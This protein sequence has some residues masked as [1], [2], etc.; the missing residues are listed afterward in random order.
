MSEYA[1]AGVDYRKIEPFKDAMVEV[2]KKTKNFPN[3]RG[4]YV[5]NEGVLHSH[6]GIY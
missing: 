3:K 4:V 2:G 1:A 6:G 5:L